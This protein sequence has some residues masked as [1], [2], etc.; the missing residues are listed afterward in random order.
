[1]WVFLLYF[2][3]TR[4]LELSVARFFGS[5]RA[6]KRG[7]ALL[8]SPFLFFSGTQD[9][10][11][12]TVFLFFILFG[13]ARGGLRYRFPLFYS[14]RAR[15]RG[16]ALPFSPFLFF[17]GTQEGACVTTFPLSALFGHARQVLRYHFPSICSFRARKKY[18]TLPYSPFLLVSGTQDAICASFL[19]IT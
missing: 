11:C 15:K 7:L 2:Y 6:S 16:L 14:F 10:S 9:G 5:F 13:H 19:L 17:S 12:V 18:L 3:C 4:W 1:M 8:F